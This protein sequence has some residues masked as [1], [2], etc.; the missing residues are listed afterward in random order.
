M[1]LFHTPDCNQPPGGN[2]AYEGSRR[3]G[4]TPVRRTP[5]KFANL[6]LRIETGVGAA[7]NFRAD[8]SEE[9]ARARGGRGHGV[10]HARHRAPGLPGWASK[11]GATESFIAWREP[12][13]WSAERLRV[14]IASSP[15]RSRAWSGSRSVKLSG[16][17][18]IVDSPIEV[19]PTGQNDRDIGNLQ[20]Q[21]VRGDPPALN[22]EVARSPTP[23]APCPRAIRPGFCSSTKNLERSRAIESTW[24]VPAL[25]RAA[26]CFGRCPLAL[27]VEI[28]IDPAVEGTVVGGAG[29]DREQV[30]QGIRPWS[31]SISVGPNPR[32]EDR[33]LGGSVEQEGE[34]EDAAIETGLEILDAELATLPDGMPLNLGQVPPGCR[35]V[36][37]RW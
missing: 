6:F 22:R 17:D 24:M 9:F 15:S 8:L 20:G 25:Q 27:R 26:Q 16:A 10:S 30:N 1:S 12:W 21:V 18:P 34:F 2:Q 29:K 4:R 23:R 5:R 32:L 13:T 33:L 14:S 31:S 11:P 28:G 35:S 7:I 3:T 37:R 36:R 19:R